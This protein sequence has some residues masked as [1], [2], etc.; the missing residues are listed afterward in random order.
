MSLNRQKDL[1]ATKI[2][3]SLKKESM[4]SMSDRMGNLHKKK[5]NHN[6]RINCIFCNR[7]FSNKNERFTN[8]FER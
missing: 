6:I 3:F 5:G 2:N 7:K 1:K 8:G 4:I